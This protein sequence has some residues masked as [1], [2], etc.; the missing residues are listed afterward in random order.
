VRSGTRL[1]FPLRKQKRRKE[2]T[3]VTKTRRAEDLRGSGGKWI[4]GS[5]SRTCVLST[6]AA[7]SRR[8]TSPCSLTRLSSVSL[9]ISSAIASMWYR[10]R[11]LGVPIPYVPLAGALLYSLGNESYRASVS[12]HGGFLSRR[13]SLE[14]GLDSRDKFV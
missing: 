4:E 8:T 3:S 1:R 2:V 13:T 10:M 9:D 14:R 7:F 11:Y 6:F 12:H 5:N